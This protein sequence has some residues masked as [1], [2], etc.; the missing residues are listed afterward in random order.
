MR[1]P[2]K[3][4]KMHGVGAGGMYRTRDRCSYGHEYTSENTLWMHGHKHRGCRTCYR[5]RAHNT[6]A[7]FKLEIFNA[8]GGKCAWPDCAVT[9]VDVLTLDHVFNDGGAERKT[10][11]SPK[12]SFATYR[13]ARREGYPARFQVLCANHQ[14]KKEILRKRSN[15]LPC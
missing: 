12:S 14:L 1:A 8:Y 9:D 10:M 11:T 13:I 6:Q 4:T 5:R 3:D 15:R 7:K 2:R